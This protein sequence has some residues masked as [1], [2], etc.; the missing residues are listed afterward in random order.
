M[1]DCNPSCLSST[2]WNS[3]IFRSSCAFSSIMLSASCR[4]FWLW[5]ISVLSSWMSSSCA[6]SS[7]VSLRCFSWLS[8]III[9]FRSISDSLWCKMYSASEMAA[10]RR[11]L[12]RFDSTIR[13]SLSVRSLPI[14]SSKNCAGQGVGSR[15]AERRPQRARAPPPRPPPL[16]FSSTSWCC[17]SARSISTSRCSSSSSVSPAP[18]SPFLGGMAT[19]RRHGRPPQALRYRRPCDARREAGP[20]CQGGRATLGTVASVHA[21]TRCPRRNACHRPHRSSHTSRQRTPRG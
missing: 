18:A 20:A 10:A 21:G 1:C 3:R 6:S 11:I 16:T 9:C 4:A 12:R 17:P 8:S 14:A 5:R 15:G 13:S 19:L 2:A 7:S